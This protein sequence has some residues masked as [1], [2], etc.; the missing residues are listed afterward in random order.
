VLETKSIELI[1]QY[2]SHALGDEADEAHEAIAI[3]LVEWA[4]QQAGERGNAVCDLLLSEI[5]GDWHVRHGRTEKALEI[6]REAIARGRS[7][8]PNSPAVLRL[9]IALAKLLSGS[10]ETR[11]EAYEMLHGMVAHIE[12]QMGQSLLDR[13]R[14]EIVDEWIELFG[15][16]IQ[17]LIAHGGELRLR[18]EGAEPRTV[19]FNLHESAKSRGFTSSLASTALAV[20][21]SVPVELREE[22]KRLLDLEREYQAD[23]AR[24]KLELETT[25][26]QR[27]R[28]IAAELEACW[29]KMDAYAPEYVKLRRGEAARLVDVKE[30]FRNDAE[31]LPKAFVS[32]FSDKEGVIWFVQRSDRPGLDVFRSA[33]SRTALTDAAKRL[34]RA[35]NGAPAEFPP[36]PPVRRTQP[37]DRE[38]GFLEALGD[39]LLA[40]LPGIA[41]VEHLCIAPHGPLHLLPIHALRMPDGRYVAEQFA[42]TY[43]PNLGSLRY[44]MARHGNESWRADDLSVYCA[45]VASRDDANPRLFEQDHEIFARQNWKKLTVASGIEA[46]RRAALRQLSEHTLVQL[47]CHGFFDDTNPLNSGLLFSNGVERPPRNPRAISVLGRGDFVLT[48]RDILRTPMSAQ[49]MTLRACSTGLQSERNAGDEFDGLSRAILHAGNAATLVSLW[50]VDQGSSQRFLACFYRNWADPA[51][52]VEKWRALWRAQKEFLNE[53]VDTFLQH[54]YHWAPLVLIGDWR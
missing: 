32:C 34:R 44:C 10:E 9:Q 50:N 2:G 7:A 46:S 49:L 12:T 38:L 18:D 30:I 21:Q 3:D 15:E 22:E 31:A 37:W 5:I 33:V 23:Q 35:F 28:E 20:P 25:R 27:L 47:T 19:A 39:E 29:A 54:P 42:I 13:R 52:P 45:G 8:E 48:T 36:F 6:F 4:Q 24:E 1:A 11:Q 26:L 41:G 17:L 16:L 51:A 53:S 14:S 43:T 40:F